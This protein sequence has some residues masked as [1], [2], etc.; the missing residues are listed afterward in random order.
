MQGVGCYVDQG[1]CWCEFC[2]SFKGFLI[3]KII[4]EYFVIFQF[5]CLN[6][7]IDEKFYYFDL[8]YYFFCL[9]IFRLVGV[10]VFGSLDFLYFKV[11][12]CFML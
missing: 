7:V 9:Y 5:L 11:V 2:R 10:V 4:V 8:Y 6:V 12:E 1:M 3:D